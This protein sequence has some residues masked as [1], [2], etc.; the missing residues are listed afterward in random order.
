[1]MEGQ[2]SL[3]VRLLVALGIGDDRDPA[4]GYVYRFSRR[5]IHKI[6]SCVQT[7]AGWQVHTAW[8]PFGSD[9]LRHFPAFKRFMYPFIH[10]PLVLRVLT[11]RPGK[12]ILKGLFETLNL[13]IG[14][15]GNCLIAVA[16]KKPQ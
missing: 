4:G 15:W 7:L 2:D 12:F 16:W 9:L 13:L 8:M 6:F 10:H 14:R 11:S 5:E 1:M 3:A